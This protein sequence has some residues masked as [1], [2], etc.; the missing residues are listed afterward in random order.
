MNKFARNNN[1][2][3]KYEEKK[4]VLIV[5]EGKNTE[6]IYFNQY[7]KSKKFN[8]VSITVKSAGN[9]TDASGIVKYACNLQER[10]DKEI[11]EK[12]FC[13]IDMDVTAKDKTVENNF[14]KAKVLAKKCKIDLIISMPC[15]ELWFLLHFKFYN[16]PETNCKNIIDELMEFE[17]NYSKSESNLEKIDFYNKYSDNLIIAIDNAKKLD[18]KNNYKYK[19]VY[20]VTYIYKIIEAIERFENTK[21]KI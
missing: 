16:K 15:I 11:F 18:S 5:G 9:T 6:K 2:H 10:H 19:E 20:P 1:T 13:V 12:I 4:A 21:K 8:K 7:K 3:K 17:K 14:T